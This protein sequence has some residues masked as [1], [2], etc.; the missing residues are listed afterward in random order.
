VISLIGNRPA[1][2]IGRHQ[3][4]D[5]DTGWI[6]DALRRAARAA[7]QADFPF[8]DE[9]RSGVVQYLETRCTLKLM[10]LEE[11]YDRMRRMLEKIGCHGIA[12]KL[13]PLAPPVTVSLVRAAMEAGN[14][15]E[16]AF[17]ETLRSELA[18]LRDAGAEEI[19]FSGLRESA[20]ILRGASK[21]N[22]HCEAML[23]EIEAFLRTLDREEC[24]VGLCAGKNA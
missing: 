9:I 12:E 15:F 10:R 21:W 22:K 19:R 20:M 24:S 18:V 11:L 5:Y 23:T 3:V 6:D 17:F 2:Q 16:L 1:L 14:G 8:V 7:D 4:I 13:Q